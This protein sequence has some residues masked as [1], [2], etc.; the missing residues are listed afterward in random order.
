MPDLAQPSIF[1]EAER[2]FGSPDSSPGFQFWKQFLVWQRALNA[3]LAPHGITQPQFSILA[4]TGWLTREGRP[5]SQQQIADLA[6]MDRMHVS[7]LVR[8]LVDQ[9]QL[10][11]QRTASDHRTWMISLTEHGRACLAITLPIVETFDAA[12]FEQP[13]QG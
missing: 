7:H 5:V 9:G 10:Q 3:R 2:L 12:F 11:R 1:P 6:G 8:R 13:V 4:V